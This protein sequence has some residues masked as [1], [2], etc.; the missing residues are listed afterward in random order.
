MLN[1][2]V[3]VPQHPQGP[4]RG[5]FTNPHVQFVKFWKTVEKLSKNEEKSWNEDCG[6]FESWAKMYD[7]TKVQSFNEWK[8]R[9][10]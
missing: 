10:L 3:T 6:R 5:T 7:L 2:H 8:D 1:R 4:G 9:M